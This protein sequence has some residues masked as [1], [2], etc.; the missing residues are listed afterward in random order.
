MFDLVFLVIFQGLITPSVSYEMNQSLLATPTIAD[1]HKALFSMDNNKSPGPDGMNLIFFKKY[2]NVVGKDVHSAIVDFFLHGRLGIA[3]NHTFITLIPKKA[4]ANRVDHFRPIALCNVAYK[5]ITKLLSNRLKPLLD[6]MI[7]PNQTA[8]IP[9]R[10]IV[11]NGIINHEVMHYLNH[12]NGK[13]TY[14]VVK[15]D[16]AKAYDKVEWSVLVGILLRHGFDNQF[17][18]LLLECMSTTTYSILINGSPCGFFPSSRGL[19]QGDPISPTLFTFLSDLLSRILARAEANGSISGVKIARGSPRI[20]HLMY[21]DDLTIYCQAN[22]EEATT[23]M[24][25]LQLYCDWTGQ[26]I[27]WDKSNIHFSSNT[28]I[29]LKHAICHLLNMKECSHHGFY[30]GN[31]FC[32]F[33]SKNLAFQS[34][35]DKLAVKLVGWKVKNLSLAGR[36]VLVKAVASAVPMYIMQTSLLPQRMCNLWMLWFGGFGGALKRVLDTFISRRGLFVGRSVQV[37]WG[38]DV[39]VIQTWLSSLNLLGICVLILPNSGSNWF[40]PTRRRVLD[41]QQ[42]TQSASWIWSGIRQCYG[43]L[44]KG[45]CIKIGPNST[46]MVYHDPWILGLPRFSIPKETLPADNI[47]FV[48]DLMNQEKTGWDIGLVNATFPTEVSN[49]I[50]SIPVIEGEHDTF[51]W[52]P[53]SSGK[54]TIRSAYRTNNSARFG[55]VSATDKEIWKHLWHSSLHER[56]KIVIWKILTNVFPTKDRI[57]QYVP[58]PDLLCFLCGERDETIHHLLFE[59]PASIAC[60]WNSPWNV[61]ILNFVELSVPD[62]ILEVLSKSTSVQHSLDDVGQ[63]QFIDFFVL[64]FEQLWQIRN[65]VRLGETPPDW[66]QFSTRLNLAFL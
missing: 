49:A 58:L 64:L 59:C 25:C 44:R 27:N 41:F 36:T 35:V 23:V 17:C 13:K 20:S 63:S 56:H 22:T 34:L 37:V 21:A 12:R 66:Q 50:L 65:R 28:S 2:W 32:S 42:T 57:K 6:T 8:F 51:V 14:M 54:F 39:F 5:I 48:R 55:L 1:V 4:A 9:H 19:R 18:Q 31:P 3:A 46:A 53:S 62:W 47:T 43:S 7:D 33:K 38:Y 26:S 11:E 52:F 24:S 16:M 40:A 30:L 10:S 45:L 29:P 60:W 15:V 61:R